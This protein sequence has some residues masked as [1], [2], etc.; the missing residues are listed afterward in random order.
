M[1]GAP[2]WSATMGYDNQTVASIRPPGRNGREKP[3]GVDPAD[4]QA[5]R[6][7]LVCNDD[8]SAHSGDEGRTA[9]CNGEVYLT[10]ESVRRFAYDKTPHTRGSQ[11]REPSV[12]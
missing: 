6:A 9:S 11:R 1:N 8:L 3:A 10:R 12:A 7:G 5:P 2:S 4:R